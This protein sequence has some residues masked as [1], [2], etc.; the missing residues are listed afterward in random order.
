[1]YNDLKGPAHSAQK[2]YFEASLSTK[3]IFLFGT[4]KNACSM[5]EMGGG[6]EGGG[7]EIWVKID[8]LVKFIFLSRFTILSKQYF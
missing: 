4:E 5:P 1:M 2:K 8:I 6:G 7:I 3:H